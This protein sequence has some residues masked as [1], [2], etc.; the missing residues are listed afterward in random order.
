MLIGEIG[1]MI[2]QH[3]ERRQPLRLDT[4]AEIRAMA[5]ALAELARVKELLQGRADSRLN[6]MTDAELERKLHELEEA[7]QDLKPAGVLH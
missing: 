5:T 7:Q 4:P 1:A 3:A 6:L 2:A